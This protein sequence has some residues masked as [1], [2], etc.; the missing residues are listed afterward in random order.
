MK[1]DATVT[2]SVVHFLRN[3][4]CTLVGGAN[5]CDSIRRP[6]VGDVARYHFNSMYFVYVISKKMYEP[7]FCR[8]RMRSCEETNRLISARLCQAGRNRTVV[9]SP[10]TMESDASCVACA[11][12][13]DDPCEPP[14][15][16]RPDEYTSTPD[17]ARGS[18]SSSRYF[19]LLEVVCAVATL[20]LAII[21]F[22]DVRSILRLLRTPPT[23]RLPRSFGSK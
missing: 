15:E 8:D 7:G 23:Q 18:S 13:A 22:M 20:V 21:G 10:Q 3:P 1:Y 16:D 9:V 14:A 19:H 12:P 4:C 11:T 2:Q 6:C 17:R 5:E